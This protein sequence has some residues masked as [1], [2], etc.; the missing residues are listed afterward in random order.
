MSGRVMGE[1]LRDGKGIQIQRIVAALRGMVP[2]DEN[3][4]PRSVYVDVHTKEV[5][6][7]GVLERLT[8]HP[9]KMGKGADAW[10]EWTVSLEDL[11]RIKFS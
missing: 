2:P 6:S 7:I 1:D 8:L 5:T 4:R 11:K 3:S 10:Y 9:T